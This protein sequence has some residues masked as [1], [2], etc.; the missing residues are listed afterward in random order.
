MNYSRCFTMATAVLWSLMRWP[1]IFCRVQLQGEWM[2]STCRAHLPSDHK[3][4]TVLV[5]LSVSTFNLQDH[6]R[7]CELHRQRMPLF[8]QPSAAVTSSYPLCSSKWASHVIAYSGALHRDTNLTDKYEC[9][10]MSSRL[11]DQT[12]IKAV[13][14]VVLPPRTR[15]TNWGE[16][17]SIPF[18]PHASARPCMCQGTERPCTGMNT[19]SIALP[20]SF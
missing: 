10:F 7:L 20:L 8:Q 2:R 14:A 17:D 1:C 4:G 11:Y 13:R 18:L 6:L 12:Q 3:P 19:R 16:K 5:A 15:R 9:L